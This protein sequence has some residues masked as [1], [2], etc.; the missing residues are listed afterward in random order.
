MMV[1]LTGANGSKKT[2][3]TLLDLKK[4]VQTPE[5]TLREETKRFNT[6]FDRKIGLKSVNLD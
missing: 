3:T 2:E 4:F 6:M 5:V 1:T